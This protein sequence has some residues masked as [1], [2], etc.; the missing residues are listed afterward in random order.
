MRR[1]RFPCLLALLLGFNLPVAAEP[2][3]P[4]SG[5]D[6]AA[7]ITRDA[8]GV[9]HIFA[10]DEHDLFFL[11]GW[12]HAEDRLFQMDVLRRTA[13]GTLA[14]L[15]GQGPAG[16]DGFPAVLESDIQLRTIGLRRA[17]ERS[18]PLLS[19]AVMAAFQAYSDGVNAFIAAH[20][21]PPEYGPLELS[22]VEPW[23]PL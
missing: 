17:A 12:V 7:R 2:P 1:L 15:L 8:D 21:L 19:P 4:L 23:T 22:A 6:A 3:T 18:L 5:L 14:E 20:P 13:S 10:T 16:P 11:Q 9:P